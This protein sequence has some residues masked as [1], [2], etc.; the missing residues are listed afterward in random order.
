MDIA[1]IDYAAIGNRIRATRLKRKITQEALSAATNL[2][3]AHISHIECGKTKL[4]LP[5]LVS[6]ATTLGVTVDNLLYTTGFLFLSPDALRSISLI[7]PMSDTS[8]DKRNR[9]ISALQVSSGDVL[10][11]SRG[12]ISQSINVRLHC[13]L[14]FLCKPYLVTAQ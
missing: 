9:A 11:F 6:I 4:S 5:A 3:I 7:L 1:T 13:F 10:L 2:S 12:K 8:S 14:V